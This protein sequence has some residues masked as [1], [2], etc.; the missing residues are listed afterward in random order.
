M[1]DIYD[2]IILGGGPAGLSSGIYS[3]RSKLKTLIIEQRRTGGQI[4]NTYEIENYPGST[5]DV[6][7]ISLMNRMKDQCQS[8]GAQIIQDKIVS[9]NL[10][11]DIKILKGKYKEYRCKALI[12]ATGS[13]PK[14]LNIPKEEEFTGKG[15]S[16]CAICDGDFFT[17]LEVFVV[18]S[19]ESAVKEGLYLTRYAKK[20]NIVS[21]SSYLKCSKMMEE[22]VYNHSKINLFFN[23]AIKKIDGN[24]VLEKIVLE[25]VNNGE[26]IECDADK[27]DGIVGLFVFIG[28]NPQTDIFK[29]II[30]V[31]SY[32]YI[33]TDENMKTN[34]DGIFAAGDCRQKMLRQIVTATND[35]AIAA[36]MAEK[37]IKEKFI[38]NLEEG[39]LYDNC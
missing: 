18:G 7:G 34:V 35:G 29:Y 30:E 39:G 8:F 22:R 1:I 6:T 17:D 31:D 3:A 11:S 4:V 13:Y 2:L 26:I 10:K 38:D 21:R 37:Y 9:M 12:I 27:D 14:K 16:Y 36:V 19:G 23:K 28:F 20:V 33:I 25:D 5:E 15:V 32:G 24:E